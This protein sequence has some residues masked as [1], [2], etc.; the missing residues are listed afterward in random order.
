[1]W[2]FAMGLSGTI[3]TSKKT[4]ALIRNY[5]NIIKALAIFS[6]AKSVVNN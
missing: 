1:M 2:Y 6:T 3:L 4:V 5:R